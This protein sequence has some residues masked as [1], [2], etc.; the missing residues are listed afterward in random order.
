LLGH[1]NLFFS[2]KVPSVMPPVM[3]YSNAHARGMDTY[4]RRSVLRHISARVIVCSVVSSTSECL[5]MAKGTVKWFNP[6]K[7]Y[8]FIQPT[9]GGKDVFVHISAVEADRWNVR[10]VPSSRWPLARRRS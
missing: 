3:I 8:G 9:S 1:Q 7:G 4:A 5:T 2:I 10:F 6:T